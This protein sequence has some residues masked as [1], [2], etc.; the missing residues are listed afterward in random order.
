MVE[1]TENVPARANP[2]AEEQLIKGMRQLEFK[3]VVT[4]LESKKATWQSLGVPESFQLG[5]SELAY[6]KPSII[7]AISLPHITEN[8]GT[9]FL[10]QAINGSGKTGAFGVPALLKVDPEVDRIQV[11]ILAN[12]R[13]LIRQIQ[14]VLQ[15]IAKHTK[16]KLLLGESGTSVAGGHILVTTPGFIKQKLGGGRGDKAGLDLGALKMVVYD[17]ADELFMQESNLVCF[18]SLQKHTKKANLT[19]QHC[20]FSATFSDDVIQT[21]KALV[22]DYTAFP[23]KKESLKLKGVKNYKLALDDKAKIEFV[24]GLHTRLDRAMTMVFV[25]RKDSAHALKQRL[26]TM[27]ITANILTGQLETADRDKMIDDFRRNVFSTLISTNV[28]A[29]GI[30]VPEVDLVINFDVPSIKLYG[31]RD[32]DYA[33]FMHRVGRTGRFG[34]DGVALTLMSEEEDPELMNLIGKHYDIEIKELSGFDELLTVMKDM[35]GD[36]Y[37]I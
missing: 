7:Q 10:F 34:T 21:A 1:Q 19:P 12:T 13:E 15:A 14:G 3:N 16:V 2:E 9:N 17:E 23:I 22:G 18:E 36:A 27:Q 28:L 25:N 35:R 11:L 5:L 37:S 31:F 24:A 8:P 26:A 29:R 32:P 20:L 33:N 4:N 30:D 6:S